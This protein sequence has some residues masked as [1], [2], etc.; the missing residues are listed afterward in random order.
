M[1]RRLLASGL[2]AGCLLAPVVANA[3]PC[4]G[5]C[6]G[7]GAVDINELIVQVEIALGGKSLDACPDAECPCSGPADLCDFTFLFRAVNAALYGCPQ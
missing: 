7:D 6:N 4:C 2:V 1:V 3:T 5:D